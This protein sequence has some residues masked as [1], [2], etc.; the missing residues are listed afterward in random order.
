MLD[1]T[2]KVEALLYESADTY[3]DAL[4]SKLKSMASQVDLMVQ[5]DVSS[6]QILFED[7]EKDKD[8][9]KGADFMKLL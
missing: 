3:R 6:Q 7:H 1:S 5:F 4:T 8:K 9:D 2:P